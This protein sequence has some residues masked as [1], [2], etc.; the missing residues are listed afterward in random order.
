[1]S[2]IIN[3]IQI[4]EDVKNTYIKQ[5]KGLAVEIML[6]LIHEY[7]SDANV[8][9]SFCDIQVF[10]NSLLNDIEKSPISVM[11]VTCKDTEQFYIKNFKY[12]GE[13]LNDL[14]NETGEVL[15][16]SKPLDYYNI[17]ISKA[18]SWEVRNIRLHLEKLEI[19]EI[20]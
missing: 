13:V 5:K 3:S 7:D 16:I 8:N 1:M 19:L 10:L 2:L 11:L 17:L 9:K 12:I 6:F 15:L 18:I 20:E 4:L 14:Q